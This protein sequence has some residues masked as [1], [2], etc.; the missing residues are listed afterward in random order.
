MVVELATWSPV[1]GATVSPQVTVTKSLTPA[2]YARTL[3]APGPITVIM[4][5]HDIHEAVRYATHILHL[6]HR[7]LFFGTAA[8]YKESDLARRFLGGNR[9]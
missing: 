9:I 3:S 8:E 5:S 7:Q 4:V 1:C 2:V 6:G